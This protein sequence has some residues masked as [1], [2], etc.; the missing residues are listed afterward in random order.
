MER[1]YR[2]VGYFLLALVP[3]FVAGFWIPY[4]SAFPRFEP[5]VTPAVHV[6]A[7][8]ATAV[9]MLNKEYHENLTDGMRA[10]SALAA[11]F[12]SAAQ[13]ALLVVFYCAAIIKIKKHEV[14]AHMRY[15][16]CIALVLLPAGLARTLGY[17][18]EVRQALSQ[19]YCL[20]VIDLCLIGLVCFDRTQRLA[21]RPCIQAL[22]AY[23]AIEAGWVA[24][25][26]PV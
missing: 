25:G 14:A 10:D 11:E 22:A 6:H 16:I 3:I 15:M 13:L 26:R 2:N 7:V 9:A 19:T 17:W 4:L 23:I 8:L 1:A 20:A 12:L 5:S 18:F 24:L 21:A